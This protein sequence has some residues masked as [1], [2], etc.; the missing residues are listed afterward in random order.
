MTE[1][2]TKN[3]KATELRCKCDYCKHEQPHQCDAQALQAL[4]AVR[5]ELGFPLTVTSAY[6]C[7]RHPSEAKK[8][9]PGTHN[10]GTAFDIALPYGELRYKLLAVA[11]KHGFNGVGF[12]HSFIH[13]DYQ[14]PTDMTWTYK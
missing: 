5:E 2:Q 4:Q 1:L 11:I 12:A 14:R 3:F 6:R 13:I 8:S 10:R 9:K 7:K